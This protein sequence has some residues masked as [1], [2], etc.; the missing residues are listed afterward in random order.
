[1]TQPIF[2]V[3]ELKRCDL[4]KLRGSIDSA[5]ARDVGDRL[6]G[7]LG[8]GHYRFVVDMSETDFISSGFLRVL[9]ATQREAKRYNRG[10]VYLAALTPRMEQVF[11]LAG[12]MPLFTVYATPAYAVGAW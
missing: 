1:M 8:R 4:I 10:D 11:E 3:T 2:E 9:V 6:R 5:R 7:L 12:L